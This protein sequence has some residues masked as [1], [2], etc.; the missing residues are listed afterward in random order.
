MTVGERHEMDSMPPVPVGDMLYNMSPKEI[1]WRTI[2][3]AQMGPED[4][5]D[6]EDERSSLLWS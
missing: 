1:D 4:E 6:Q 3:T 5:E 2:W